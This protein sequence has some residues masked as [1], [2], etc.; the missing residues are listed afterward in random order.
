MKKILSSLIL[1]AWM[2]HGMAQSTAASNRTALFNGKDLSGW[3]QLGGQ[4]KYAVIN[5]MIVGTAVPHSANSFLVTNQQYDDFILD[6]DVKVDTG[7]NSGIQVRSESTPDYQNGRV[8]GY[9]VEV[10]PSARAWS[11]GIYD[12]AR[13]GWLYPLELNPEAKKAFKNGQWNHYHIECIGNTIRVWVNNMPTANLVDDMTHK[14]FIG[15]Q[16]HAVDEKHAGEKVYFKNIYIQTQHLRPRPYDHIFVVNLIPNNLSAQ[17]IQNGVKLL[18]DG[19]TTHGWRGINLSH[20]PD[21]GWVIRDGVLTVLP[22]NGQEEGG[23]G[24]IITEQEYGAFDL[25]FQFKLTPGANSGVKYFVKEFYDT[26]GKSGIGLEYQLLDDQRHPDA[27]LG[28][29]GNRT[30]SSLYDL[31]PRRN[32]AAAFKPIGEWNWGRIVVYPDGR[33]QHWLNG[34]LM[35]EYHRGDDAFK[36]LVF[37]SKYKN[38]QNFGLWPEGHILLQDHGNEVSFRSIKIRVLK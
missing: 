34:Y 5:G 1:L 18:W 36:Q 8:H 14:G 27:K 22:S 2:Q 30:L 3:H 35:L 28:V 20:F 29:N 4:A 6:I 33:V 11:G 16:V 10:D 38:W 25:Q 37:M 13:R 12:E 15:L 32:I 31:I 21:H 23:G 7:L 26:H 17:E 19:Q 9:Q 24:D